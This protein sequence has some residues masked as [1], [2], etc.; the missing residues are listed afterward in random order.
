MTFDARRAPVWSAVGLPLSLVQNPKYPDYDWILAA[1]CDMM[2]V[3]MHT[4]LE[5][6]LEEYVNDD[7]D[8]DAKN[9]HVVISEDGR[10]LAYCLESTLPPQNLPLSGLYA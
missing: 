10:G 3:N 7:V 8:P 5:R 1:D 2:F 9:V 6:I 4:P